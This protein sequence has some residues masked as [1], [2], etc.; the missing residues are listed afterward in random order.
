MKKPETVTALDQFRIQEAAINA[1]VLA[2]EKHYDRIIEEQ[3]KIRERAS[4]ERA[5]AQAVLAGMIA[6]FERI[7]A[8]L[9]GEATKRMDLAGLTKAALKDGRITA[10]DYFK[11]GISDAQV[12][13]KAQAD[14]NAK[15]ADLREVTRAQAVRVLELEEAELEAD[16]NIA[17][18]QVAPAAAF[19]ERLAALLKAL[20]LSLASP[21]GVTGGGFKNA[22]DVKRRELRNATKGYMPG[23]GT[24]WLD[25]ADVAGLKRLRLDP[26]WPLEALPKLEEIIAEAKTTGRAC[27]L[28]LDS[29]DRKDP[30]RVMWG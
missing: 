8:E 23:D 16:Y 17:F 26:T 12:I 14:A 10:G 18:A 1:D 13:A 28:M 30:V 29:R 25:F 20:E 7:D 27:R 6:D 15:L 2:S 5:K 22:L 4:A 11:G 24:G 21:L 3:T 9:E 19:R